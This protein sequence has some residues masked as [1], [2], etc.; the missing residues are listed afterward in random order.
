M[1]S[2]TRFGELLIL[3]PRQEFDRLVTAHESD[4]YRK[5]FSSWSHLVTMMYAQLSACR[6][7]RELETS[8]NSH[9][10]RHYHLGTGR[11]KRSTLSDA[12]QS[13]DATVYESLCQV[14]LKG[15]HRCVRREIQDVLY[16]LD[17]TPICLRGRGYEWT[18]GQSQTHIPGLKLH[19]LYAPQRGL[20]CWAR[21]TPS[22]VNDVQMGW[23]VAPEN[24]AIY[25]FDK[26]YCDYNWWHRLDQAGA[27]FV[28]RFKNNA[29]LISESD[30]PIPPGDQD[31][32]RADQRV[33]F[34]YRHPGGG[35]FNHYDKPLRRIAVHR[36]G[37]T[38]PLILAT[39][40]LVN[41]AIQIAQHYKTRWDIELWFKWIKQRLKIKSFL[42]RSVNAVR[43]QIAIALITFLLAD[44]YRQMMQSKQ[45]FYLW[46]TELKATLFN[47]TQ[48][49]YAVR[50]SK[51]H[52]HQQLLQ[53]QLELP[54]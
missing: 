14:L 10:Q 19:V 39:N 52:R 13:R 8:Y 36:P 5:G 16:I 4:K 31:T 26:G 35:R 47:R 44:Q 30:H 54:I 34:K 29:G 37:H 1:R 32:I 40:D 50:K 41:P 42:G 25:V 28:T 49:E 27:T 18:Q 21:V 46:L 15:S 45:E 53:T 48:N 43:I 9:S 17:S 3:F 20:P 22:N 6:S 38:R 51:R 7:L 23:E 11:V 33:R 2:K 24:G 12:N